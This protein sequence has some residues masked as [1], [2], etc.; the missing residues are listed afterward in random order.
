MSM[1]IRIAV[2]VAVGYVGLVTIL[3]HF[4]ERIAFPAPRSPLPPP[5]TLG[6]PT[7][8]RVELVTSDSVLITGWYL[9]PDDDSELAPGLLWFIGNMETVDMLAPLIRNLRPSGTGL[10]IINYRG[11]GDSEGRPSEA[12]VYRDAEAAWEFLANRPEIDRT[13]IG[14][15]GR[16]IGSAPATFIASNRPVRALVLDSPFTSGGDLAKKHYRIFPRFL[17]RLKMNNLERIRELDIPVLIFHGTS[18]FVVP[19]E[20]GRTLAESAPQ[21]EF[22]PIEGASHNDTYYMLGEDE[23]RARMHDFL[24]KHLAASVDIGDG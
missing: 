9:P 4:Q 19:F 16:S 10:L 15:Y 6:F 17:I 5:R 2:F 8:E 7:G 24:D 21:G 23:Y 18:D 3:W 14:A 22:V 11:Y 12:G 1:V 20:M 13:R